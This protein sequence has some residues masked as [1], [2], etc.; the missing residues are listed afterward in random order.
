M[1]RAVAAARARYVAAAEEVSGVRQAIAGRLEVA[2]AAELPPLRLEK[3]RFYARV[4]R[5]PEADWGPHGAESVRFLIS[6]NPGQ[7][8][9]ALWGRSRRAGSFRG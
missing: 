2:V 1:V 9:G 3:A 6:T 7:A 8:P 5:M 4:E